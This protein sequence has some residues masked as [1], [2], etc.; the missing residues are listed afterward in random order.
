MS[1]DGYFQTRWII[2]NLIVGN[3]EV[4]SIFM[5]GIITPKVQMLATQRGF[6]P[7]ELKEFERFLELSGLQNQMASIKIWMPDGTIAYSKFHDLIGRRFNPEEIASAMA[8]ATVVTFDELEDE[9]NEHEGSLN[10]GELMEIYIP[11]YGPTGQPIAVGEFYQDLMASHE[12]AKATIRGTWAIRIAFMLIGLLVLFLFVR[13][14]D[15]TIVKQQQQLRKNYLV[16][17]K[18]ARQNEELRAVA[19]ETRRK[20]VKANEE[21][22]SLIGAEIHDGPL[23]VLGLAMLASGKGSS[24]SAEAESGG[25]QLPQPSKLTAEAMSQLRT[26]SSGLILPEL[27][28]LSASEAIRLAIVKHEKATGTRVAS[29]IDELPAELS[30]GLK[31]CMYRF[32]QECLNNSARH[33]GGADQ[34]VDVVLEGTSVTLAVCDSGPGIAAPLESQTRPQLGLL[35]ARNRVES[36]GGSIEIVS[37]ANVGTIVRARLPIELEPASVS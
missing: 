27:G 23:Q 19:E 24:T 15:K 9:E 13:I 2:S 32:V 37:G 25:R 29:S 8:G 30:Q 18:L 22:L 36:F 26:I 10:K 33:A 7:A 20:A 3:A 12:I 11:I 34:R 16:A 6:S 1:V 21:L 5:R 35:G 4:A 14:A 28:E 17:S 31:A